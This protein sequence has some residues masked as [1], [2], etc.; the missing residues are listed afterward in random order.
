MNIIQSITH[1]TTHAQP[2]AGLATNP[3]QIPNTTCMNANVRVSV[4]LKEAEIIF[5]FII[6]Y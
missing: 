4:P 1:K 5:L 2:H 6:L 3:A